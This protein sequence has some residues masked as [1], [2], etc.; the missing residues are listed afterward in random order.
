ME[1]ISANQ[2]PSSR[3]LPMMLERSHDDDVGTHISS[4]N[5]DKALMRREWNS[6]CGDD[7]GSTATRM[8]ILPVLFILKVLPYFSK[9][10][11]SEWPKNW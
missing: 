2:A 11:T 8:K 5:A 6:A 9:H 3:L 4:N 10:M 1:F 7:R